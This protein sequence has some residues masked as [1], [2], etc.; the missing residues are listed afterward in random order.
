MDIATLHRY[1]DHPAEAAGW[2]AR[3]RLDDVERGH[4]NLVRMALSGITLDLL[5]IIC[6][7]LA[8]QLPR[9]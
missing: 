7:Q 5:A 1:L 8:E 4:G 9:L 3:W 2:L 6:D